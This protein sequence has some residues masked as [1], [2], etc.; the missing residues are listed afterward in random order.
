MYIY[1]RSYS[2]IYIAMSVS[3]WPSSRLQ[4]QCVP[5]CSSSS[6]KAGL[7]ILN[8]RHSS[9]VRDF[10]YQGILWPGSRTWR[11][12]QA[13]SSAKPDSSISH[14]SFELLSTLQLHVVPHFCS[15][16]LKGGFFDSSSVH[17]SVVRDFST[18]GRRF[19]GGGQTGLAWGKAVTRA[20]VLARII[21]DFM[22]W[23]SWN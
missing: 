19:L 7:H 1:I 10:G 9:S 12:R 5:H 13:V 3:S 23:Y 15:S 17:S 22:V 11:A 8:A 6:S 16:S 21:A 4:V 18:Q 14:F 2:N 20:R